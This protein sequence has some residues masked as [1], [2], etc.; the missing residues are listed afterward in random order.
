MRSTPRHAHSTHTWGSQRPILLLMPP[1]WRW[2]VCAS[3][4]LHTCPVC[5]T[6]GPPHTPSL[7]ERSLCAQPTLCL[8]ALGHCSLYVARPHQRH[9][10]RSYI[11]LTSAGVGS[12][13]VRGTHSCA[14]APVQQAALMHPEGM[15]VRVHAFLSLALPLASPLSRSRFLPAGPGFEC[16]LRSRS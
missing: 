15:L 8:T 6:Y 4:V 10:L 5:V 3:E 1:S 13:S 9:G 7:P 12:F 14:A 16:P 11:L 2:C